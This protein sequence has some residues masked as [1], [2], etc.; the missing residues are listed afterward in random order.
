MKTGLRTVF[1][2]MK[3]SAELL[4][5]HKNTNK[6]LELWREVFKMEGWGHKNRICVKREDM[7]TGTY[8]NSMDSKNRLI[9]PGKVQT[10]S[11]GSVKRV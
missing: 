5:I 8:E 6:E 7:F 1:F 2:F 10:S 9:I 4:K 3:K 11:A